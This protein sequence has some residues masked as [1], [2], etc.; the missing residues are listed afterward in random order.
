M[1]TRKKRVKF[2]HWHFGAIKIRLTE[3]VPLHWSNGG[4]T[5]EGFSVQHIRWEFDGSGVRREIT[6]HS[7]DCDGPF[8]WEADDY[9]PI[10]DLHAGPV[11]PSEP[12]VSYP[13]WDRLKEQQRDHAAEAMGY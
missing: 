12:L 11:D 13:L 6:N 10:E 3:G 4:P 7:R 9:C 5:D 1:K 2:W 8:D